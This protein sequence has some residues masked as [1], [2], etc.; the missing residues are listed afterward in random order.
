MG[1]GPRTPDHNVPPELCLPE[2]VNHVRL[3]CDMC[4]MLSVRTSFREIIWLGVNASAPISKFELTSSWIHTGPSQ[5]G[6][7]GVPR[8]FGSRTNHLNPGFCAWYSS[9]HHTTLNIIYLTRLGCSF[10]RHIAVIWITLSAAL[11][12]ELENGRLSFS[13]L[14]PLMRCEKKHL[15][16]VEMQ[17]EKQ[18]PRKDVAMEKDAK[19]D[20]ESRA[21][22]M[23]KR[24]RTTLPCCA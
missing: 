4:N 15:A 5:E 21:V 18:I 6:R 24:K 16:S 2:I 22:Q 17:N 12:F 11:R 9:E 20:S 19:W 13:G 14:F 23:E 3:R 10:A 7:G 8:M 1:V